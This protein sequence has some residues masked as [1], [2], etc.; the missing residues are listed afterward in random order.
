MDQKATPVGI[1]RHMQWKRG[2]IPMNKG[3]ISMNTEAYRHEKESI[4]SVNQEALCP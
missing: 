1:G 2:I 3:I 4:I